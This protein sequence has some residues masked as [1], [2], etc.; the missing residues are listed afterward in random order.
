MIFG[1]NKFKYYFFYL[2]RITRFNLFI[3]NNK[4]SKNNRLIKK[5]SMYNYIK[6]VNIYYKKIYSA[7]YFLRYIYIYKKI[8]I[9]LIKL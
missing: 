8:R 2:S 3:K 5:K 7:N 9:K 4:L 1:F 6:N